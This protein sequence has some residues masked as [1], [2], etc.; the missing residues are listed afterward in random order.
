[1]AAK[2]FVS[3]GGLQKLSYYP[4]P[5]MERKSKKNVRKSSENT[6]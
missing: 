2:D 5:G 3:Y 6:H 4:S 1:M